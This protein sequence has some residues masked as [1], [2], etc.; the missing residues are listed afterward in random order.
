MEQVQEAAENSKKR[1]P[2]TGKRSTMLK[3]VDL[4]TAKQLQQ[5]KDRANKKS[6]GRKVKDSEVLALAIRLVSP[7]HIK[8]L[9]EATYSEK[10]RLS[11]IHEEFQKT[12]GKISLDQFIGK[13]LK[14]EVKVS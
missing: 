12:N 14:G 8:E 1:A 13:L 10:D 7:E 9:Q 6:F 2:V 4:E 3:K 11:M 5:I